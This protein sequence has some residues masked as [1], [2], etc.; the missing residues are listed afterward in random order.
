M[1]K[2]FI[3]EK[4]GQ[5]TVEYLLVIMVVVVTI[6][7]LGPKVKNLMGQITDQVFGNVSASIKTM[8]GSTK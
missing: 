7:F 4:K 6:S 5:S 1:M 8:M 2:Q 3:K